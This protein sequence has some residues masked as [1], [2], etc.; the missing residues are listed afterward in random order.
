[1]RQHGFTIPELTPEQERLKAAKRRSWAC[2]A[3]REAGN[4]FHAGDYEL[5]GD[6]IGQAA[7]LDPSRSGDWL[8]RAQAIGRRATA[9]QDT[10][11]YAA[12]MRAMLAA[13]GLAAEVHEHQEPE[14][15]AG[16]EAELAF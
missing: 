12:A 1:M 7:S 2:D 14:A 9:A 13:G 11:G 6:L 8:V 15:E 3:D 10:M 4:A 16:E 5:A